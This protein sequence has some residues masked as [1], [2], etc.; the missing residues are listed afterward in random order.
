[1]PEAK[2]NP[3]ENAVRVLVGLPEGRRLLQWLLKKCDLRGPI[4]CGDPETVCR[5]EA[6]RDIGRELE[7]LIAASHGR[8][9]IVEIEEEKHS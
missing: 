3:L 5:R 4:F 7:R 2:K 1:M 8:K 6:Q 9:K